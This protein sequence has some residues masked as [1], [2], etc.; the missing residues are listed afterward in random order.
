MAT[1]HPAQYL[2]FSTERLRPALDLLA[3]IPLEHVEKI[4]D[5]GCG[6]GSVI[7]YLRQRW[8]NAHIVGVDS[9]PDMLATAQQQLK[10]E[11]IHWQLADI[12]NW[13]SSYAPF[14]VLF[15]N[16]ALHWLPNHPHL[17]PHLLTHLAKNGVFAMQVPNN[18]AFP[19]HTCLFELAKQNFWSPY[20]TPHLPPPPFVLSP[21]AYYVL[22]AKHCQ[23]VNVWQTTYYHNLQ[24]EHPIFEW[25]KGSWLRP[26]LDILPLELHQRFAADYSQLLANAYPQDAQGKTLL[27]FTRL[28]C[29]AIK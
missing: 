16:A 8:G 12:A 5:I 3:Q 13:Q 24:G 29:I 26:I 11:Q 19:T 28:F 2:Q 4:A 1:W 23:S 25:I 9:S 20:L 22:L 17:L 10:D 7:P 15:S 18:F 21:E 6:T 27:A 14:D